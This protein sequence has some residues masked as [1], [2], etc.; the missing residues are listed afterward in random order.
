MTNPKN[1]FFVALHSHYHRVRQFIKDI[2]ITFWPTWY[3]SRLYKQCAA[4][5]PYFVDERYGIYQ[6]QGPYTIGIFKDFGQYHKYYISACRD[7]GISYKVLDISGP[8]WLEVVKHSNCDG[9]LVWPSAVMSIRKEMYDERLKIIAY[10]L[11]KI[12]FPSYDELWV[13]ESKRRMHYWLSFHNI[14]QP[15]TWVFYDIENALSFVE[16]AKFPLVYKSN[17]GDSSMGVTVLRSPKQ[18]L[19]ILKKSFSRGVPLSGAHPCERQWGNVLFQEYIKDHTEWRMIR[20]GESYFGY[21]KKRVDNFASGVHSFSYLHP[22]DKL[23]DFVK[24]VTDTGNFMSMSLD[25][26]VTP[27]EKFFV[28]ELQSLFGYHI[29]EERPKDPDY[30]PGRYVYDIKKEHWNFEEGFFDQNMC[31]NL[32]VGALIKKLDTIKAC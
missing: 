28:I 2:I 5:N 25:I 29:S 8:E 15:K 11:E 27:E 31:C 4:I 20:I 32:R 24:H 12:L 14:F 10:D 21:V 26:L 16:T 23:L 19:R 1:H 13:W 18:A 7:M 3:F 30:K 6:G 17:F 9:F 22:S